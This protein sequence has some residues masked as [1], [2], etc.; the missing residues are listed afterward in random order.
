MKTSVLILCKN[1]A[2]NISPCLEAVFAQVG[3]GPY[4]VILVDSGSTDKTRELAR[5]YPVRIE[6]IPAASFHH[7]R[8]R[9]YAAS[10]ANGEFLVYLAADAIP[11]TTNWLRNMVRDFE[12][13]QVGAVYGK[14]LP[15]PGS[16]LEREETLGAIYG[17]KRL[18]KE[19]GTRERLGYKYY[20]LSTVNA[21]I[22]KNVWEKTTFPEDL[23]VFED[24]GIA[25]KILDGGWKIVY[26]PEASVYHSHH[27]TARALFRRYFD[28][29]YTMRKLSIWN[30]QARGSMLRDAWK[31]FRGKTAQVNRN[32]RNRKLGASLIQS[33]AKSAGMF[34]GLNEKFLPLTVKR[35]MSAFRVYE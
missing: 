9:N 11:V 31:M 2:A 7:A 32:G 28:I 5:E 10:L 22:R 1:E 26:E 33:M 19:P 35:R 12:D 4:E 20:H 16:S 21:A 27:H 14:H 29:G 17:D 25:K 13:P 30:D 23:K 8:T 18:V 6:E 34:F 24:L 15:K 3:A